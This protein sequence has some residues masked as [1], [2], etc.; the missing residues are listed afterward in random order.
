[1][2]ATILIGLKGGG[3]VLLYTGPLCPLS[4]PPPPAPRPSLRAPICIIQGIPIVLSPKTVEWC[5]Y[6]PGYATARHGES[7]HD[8]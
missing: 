5:S 3:G 8:A 7:Y 4:P 2:G 1:M 6:A